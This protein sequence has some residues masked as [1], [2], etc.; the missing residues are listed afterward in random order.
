M[1]K[2]FEICKYQGQTVQ[3]V[4]CKCVFYKGIAPMPVF[5]VHCLRRAV[6]WPGTPPP[7]AHLSRKLE[8]EI[9]ISSVTLAGDPD[10]FMDNL[11]FKVLRLT[12]S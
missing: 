5:G 6:S 1:Q 3:N 2:A 12:L 9:S 4:S 8:S 10:I 7:R 11:T